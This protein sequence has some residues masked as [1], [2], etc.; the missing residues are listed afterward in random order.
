MRH[1]A[2]YF[3]TR[4]LHNQMRNFPDIRLFFVTARRENK[5]AMSFAQTSLCF[6]GVHCSIVLE[7]P[8]DS[9]ILL[10]ISGTDTGELG[11]APMR[12]LD[13][14]L[15]LSGPVKLFIDARAVRGASIDVSSEWAAW[16]K[17][18]RTQLRSITML[19][20]IEVHSDYG[21]IRQTLCRSQ[22]N[23]VGLHR[24]RRVR[25]CH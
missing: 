12:A 20:G 24:A 3:V 25:P 2:R 14:W 21:G 18:R 10:R 19:T 7:Q 17:E 5:Y 8:S 23:Y 6:E 16:L 13:A 9:A 1:P 22:W 15:D 4:G 11:D